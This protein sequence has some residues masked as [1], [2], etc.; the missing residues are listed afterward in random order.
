MTLSHERGLESPFQ[1]R[2]YLTLITVVII[3]GMNQGLL[4]PLLTLLL[5]KTGV[6]TGVNGL[7][8]AALYI[9]TFATMF[10]IEKPVRRFGYKPVIVG[11]ILIVL[12]ALILFPSFPDFWVWLVLRFMVGVGDSGL[13]YATQLWIVSRSPADKRGRYISLYGMAY[14]AGFS[15]GPLGINLLPYGMWAPFLATMLCTV[16]SLMFVSRLPNALPE[17]VKREPGAQAVTTYPAV[18]RLAWYALLT[19]FL[20]G[21]MESSMN[22]NFPAYGLR[23]G[24]SDAWISLLLPV[25]GIGSLILQLPLGVWSD[26][27][28]RKP[29]LMAAGLIGGAAFAAVPFASQGNLLLVLILFGLAGGLVGSFFTLGL[30]YAADV[31]PKAVLPRTNVIASVLFSIGSI[32]GPNIG[33]FSMQYFSVHS[34][35]YWLGGAYVLFALLGLWFRPKVP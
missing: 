34:M 21:Y 24:M 32:T 6:S 8:A 5:D 27:W 29:I 13:H 22:S 35:F 7:N 19:S 28:G 4:L 9:G 23:I 2:H 30:A 1:L 10:W 16:V 20:Y 25:I 14:G 15:L 18:F 3:A 31:V 33:G 11:G 17:T 12:V 26:R